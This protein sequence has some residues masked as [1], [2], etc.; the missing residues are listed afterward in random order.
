MTLTEGSED[1]YQYEEVMNYISLPRSFVVARYKIYITG[2]EVILWLVKCMHV[3]SSKIFYSQQ[4]QD[5]C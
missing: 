1:D 5:P 3:K 4:S 2:E